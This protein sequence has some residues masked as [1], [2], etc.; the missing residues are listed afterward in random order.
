MKTFPRSR[1]K[2]ADAVGRMRACEV[3]RLSERT[4]TPAL[5]RD[6]GE[7]TGDA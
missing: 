5:S 1:E 4:L 6:A 2:V 7:R 3:M